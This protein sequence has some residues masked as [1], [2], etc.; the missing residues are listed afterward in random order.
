M[1][2]DELDLGSWIAD[3]MPAL[4][5][6][7]AGWNY[8]VGVHR[9]VSAL[10]AEDSPLS[11]FLRAESAPPEGAGRAERTAFWEAHDAAQAEARQAVV[12]AVDEHARYLDLTA[13]RAA[14][15]A[16]DARVAAAAESARE[17]EKGSPVAVHRGPNQPA[18]Y[19][20]W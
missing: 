19:G 1:N 13:K 4:A 12:D 16:F 2:P 14:L 9:P 15:A 5:E 6:A 7:E 18:V 17:R 8:E 10:M 3:S 11:A 20:Q